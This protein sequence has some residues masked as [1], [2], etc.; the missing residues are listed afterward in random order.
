MGMGSMH[1]CCLGRIS[2]LTSYIHIHDLDLLPGR[3]SSVGGRRQARPQLQ[4]ERYSQASISATMYTSGAAA[5]LVCTTVLLLIQVCAV[6]PCLLQSIG[7]WLGFDSTRL[8]AMSTC[9]RRRKGED[10]C[11]RDVQTVESS[12][13]RGGK[14]W[15]VVTAVFVLLVVVALIARLGNH[16]LQTYGRYVQRGRSHACYGNACMSSRR[17]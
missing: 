12:I 7:G 11:S 6:V 13:S 15:F 5:L 8:Q 4:Y 16:S 17:T 1:I 2:Y 10:I 9:G 14:P 3:I